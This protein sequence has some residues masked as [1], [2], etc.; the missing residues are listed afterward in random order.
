MKLNSMLPLALALSIALFATA[1]NRD[2]DDTVVDEPAVVTAPVEPEPTV[3]PPE[4]AA[5]PVDSGT[6][7][8]EMDA[9]G[10]GAITQDELP[11]AEMLSQHFS[12]ADTDGN[13]ALSPEEVDAHRAAMADSH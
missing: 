13:G 10:D 4:P 1:C 5:H 7:F 2:T 9:S 11:E 6:S 8:A 3:P 12:V